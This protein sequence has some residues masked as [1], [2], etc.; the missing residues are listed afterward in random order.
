MAVKTISV[1]AQ[2]SAEAV[3]RIQ[4]QMDDFCPKLIVFFASSIYAATNP[5]KE[6]QAAYPDCAVIGS[7]SHSEYCGSTFT[8]SSI[9]VMA[10]D[11]QTVSQVSVKVVEGIDGDPDFD[12][13][14]KESE[15]AFGGGD[16]ILENFDRF[17]GIVLFEAS[18]KAEELCM[19]RIGN[20]TD[21]FY[22]GGTSSE[23]DGTSRVY[24]NGKEYENAAVLATLKTVSGYQILKTQ[25][26]QI[27]S[28]R[29][30]RVTKSDSKR[31]VMY[32]L[33]HRPV[34]EVYA[35]AL[36]VDTK[37]IANYFVSNPLGVV[38][39][40]EIFVR[41][42]NQIVDGGISLHC[43][44]PE[45]TEIHILKIGDIVADTKAALDGVIT[46][47]VA[48]V[49]NF[50]CLYRTLEITGKNLVQPYCDLFGRYP[51]IGFSTAGEAFLGH[52]NETSTVLI[53]K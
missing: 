14:I 26:A 4:Q 5:A 37:E 36:G 29:G 31:R 12:T 48:G 15:A 20:A 21:L 2:T 53:L 35:E 3:N 39:E 49:M 40:N 23:C 24:A 38:A 19:D 22:V 47:P 52:I 27:F 17:V 1:K 11:A 13:P 34:D 33:D 28:Q 25:S 10:I 42:F 51:S 46:A 7:T 41:T 50:N 8:D 30:Y 16:A 45:G 43:G 44:I 32:E 6:L 9:A 18:A